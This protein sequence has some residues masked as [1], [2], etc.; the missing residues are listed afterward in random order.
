MIGVW[1]PTA[2][3]ASARKSRASSSS[4]SC[5][6][7]SASASRPFSKRSSSSLMSVREY[8]G[9]VEFTGE[10]RFLHLPV[11]DGLGVLDELFR[12]DAGVVEVGVDRFERRDAGFS[13]VERRLPFL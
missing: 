4:G 7:R 2:S 13:R 12:I 6:S 3:S 11:L 8:M 1:V 10:F 9:S 5:F